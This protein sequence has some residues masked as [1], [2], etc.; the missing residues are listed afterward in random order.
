MTEQVLPPPPVDVMRAGLPN[1]RHGRAYEHP[2]Q[3]RLKR[4]IGE[5]DENDYSRIALTFGLGLADHLMAEREIIKRPQ[6]AMTGLLDPSNLSLEISTGD[7]DELTFADMFA[8]A[9]TR[10]AVLID[11]HEFQERRF[12]K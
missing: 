6:N 12:F 11:P 9:A 2:L 4:S 8:P 5:R 10:R 7:I 1:L 3:H